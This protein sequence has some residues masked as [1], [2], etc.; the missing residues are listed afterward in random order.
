MEIISSFRLV[1][2][3]KTGIETPEWSRLE[4]LE[5][6]LGNNFALSDTE[7]TPPFC[8]IE[9]VYQIYLCWEHYLALC[10]KYWEPSFWEVMDTFVLLAYACLA[11]LRT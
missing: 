9:G 5:K 8:W 10:Q 3:G 2:E 1:L 4:F 6:I 11:T 7:V